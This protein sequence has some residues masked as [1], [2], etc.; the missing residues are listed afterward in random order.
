MKPIVGLYGIQDRQP[1]PAPLETHD[2]ALCRVEAGRVVEHI[3]LERHTRR[4]HDNRLHAWIEALAPY[5][6]A[7]PGEEVILACADSFVGRSFI[8]A[9][10]RW[11]VEAAP[12]T[13]L[14]AALVPA[15]AHV[16]GREQE[17]WIVPHELA[18]VGASLPFLG[19]WEDG[20]LLVHLDGAASLSCCSAW[21]WAEGSLTRLAAGWDLAEPVA[22]YGTNNLAQALVGH[23]WREF[24]Q[25]PGKLMALAAY[26][27]PDPELAAWLA[28]HDWFARMRGGPH[29]FLDAARRELGWSGTLTPS[30]R[31]V[32]N[33]AACFQLRFED[34]VVA[35][36]EQVR[37]TSGARRLVIAGGGA[38]NLPT[39]QRLC[40]LGWFDHV[41]V[42]PCPGDDGLGLGA[43]ALV[44]WLH[45]GAL[46][47]HSPFLNTT[48][49]PPLPVAPDVVPIADA[50][51]QGAIVATCLGPGEV[52]PRALGR[53]SLLAL[54]SVHAVQRVSVTAKGREAW[55]PVAP[56]VLA[57][58]AGRLFSGAPEKSPLAPYMLGRFAADERAYR[59]APGIVH[60]DGTARVQT[61]GHEPDLRPIRR[62]LEALWERHG[63]P[64]L[65]NTSFNVRGEPLVQT[66]EDAR[67]TAAA[68]GVDLLWHGH[69]LERVAASVVSP[70]EFDAVAT[71]LVS[72]RTDAV[73]A[74]VTS[75]LVDRFPL[76]PELAAEP[77]AVRRLVH[78]LGELGLAR[79]DGVTW[80]LTSRGRLLAEEH[81]LSLG[82]AA[83]YWAETGR[84]AWAR[85]PAAVGDAAFAP[86]DP[87]VA[88]AGTP[89][90]VRAYHRAMAPYAAR[91]YRDLPTVVYPCETLLDAGGGLGVAA[92]LLLNAAVAARAVVLD[93]SEVTGLGAVPPELDGRLSFEAFD[94]FHPWPACGDAVLLARVLHDWGDAEARTIL[95][96]ARSALTPGGRVYVVE[97]VRPEEGFDGALLDLHML[98]ATGGRER[99]RAEFEALLAD[100]ELRLTALR[101]LRG[102]SSV[103]VAEPA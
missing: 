96:R 87:F 41:F 18:H 49:S 77:E 53:R 1:G 26:G 101:P 100:A 97:M 68:L 50:L 19:G 65:A 66:L 35:W 58:L 72:W 14:C 31:L 22:G 60:V 99:T 85:L 76:G 5:G 44:A 12:A 61:V 94:L 57:E 30:D 8:S 73:H 74:A 40:D 70:V 17:A 47:R 37:R 95:R 83:R 2:H 33:I 91:D 69:G 24:L 46:D 88:Q 3:A 54:P 82:P 80:V 6:Y 55:R 7:A 36:I 89:E 102:V 27:E 45:G 21:E 71:D 67:T 79:R 93:R 15:R 56:I 92:R 39:N 13:E 38:L 64:C 48:G 42:P 20:T 51:A 16:H 90:S 84:A 23:T 103:L 32:R 63:I 81:P 25:V 34:A 98:L 52:G 62:L 10:G 29:P 43:A 9:G 11:R 86:G 28:R 75:G 78:A 59:E 4:R